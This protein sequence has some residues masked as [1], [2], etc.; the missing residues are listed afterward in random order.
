MVDEKIDYHLSICLFILFPIQQCFVWE[1]VS[2]DIQAY[3]KIIVL[4]KK[5]I[6]V[7]NCVQVRIGVRITREVPGFS[8]QPLTP[9][10]SV[11]KE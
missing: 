6:G 5:K 9:Q 10:H 11:K 2:C 1:Y 3:N 4:L 8:L 7:E